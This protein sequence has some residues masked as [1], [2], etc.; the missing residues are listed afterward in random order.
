MVRVTAL[1]AEDCR[2]HLLEAESCLQEAEGCCYRAERVSKA[3]NRQVQHGADRLRAE[4]EAFHAKVR[5]VRNEHFVARDYLK[6]HSWRAGRDRSAPRVCHMW[7]G[8]MFWFARI[9]DACFISVRLGII[10]E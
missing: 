9:G 8:A 10:D 3:R 5:D 2:E 4:T 6:Q 1:S 7:E